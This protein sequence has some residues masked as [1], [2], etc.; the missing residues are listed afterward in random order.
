M[1]FYALISI[2]VLYFLLA[3]ASDFIKGV[4]GRKVCAICAAVSLTWL[5]LL[6]LWFL[7][8]EVDILL[9]AIL[10]GGS[11]VGA[12]YKVEEIFKKKKWEK[13]W[14]VRLLIILGGTALVYFL[15]KGAT[16]LFL[17]TAL[18]LLVVAWFMWVLSLTVKRG[19]GPASPDASQGGPESPV[20]SKR[21]SRAISELEEKL[22]NCC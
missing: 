22:K 20:K 5:W 16:C 15:L 18:I 10:M 6:V 7:E 8:I 13:F 3:A 12:M 4:V 21:L 11:I 2:T 17:S 14:L 1:I 19:G 9:I